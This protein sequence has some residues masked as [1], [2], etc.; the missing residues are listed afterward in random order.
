MRRLYLRI[1]LAVLVSLAVFALC[2]AVVWRQLGDTGPAGHAFEVA[3]TLA[4]NVLP[5]AGAPKAEQQAALEKFA[6]N[7]RADVT[8][9]ATD[10]SLL[11]AV[12]EPVPAPGTGRDRSGWLHR[13]GGPSSGAI[14]LP[15]GRWLVAGVPR[16]RGHPGF[17]L[18]FVLALIALG[19]GVGAY[20]VVRRLT[21]RLERLQ[22]GVESLGA[23]DLSARVKVEGHDEVAR[24]AE[25]FNRGRGGAA[26]LRPWARHSGRG[27]RG[28]VSTVPPVRGRPG[29]RGG[30]IG[31]I[32]GPPDRAPTR[33]RCAVRRTRAVREL[34]RH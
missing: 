17:P 20:P 30:R 13:W 1:Y 24:L 21:V 2:S 28:R 19:V 8:L 15:D 6:A 7:L 12:G 31:A 23:G 5:P 16:G 26:R 11:A 33:R 34:L 27:A 25:S 29:Q 10:R 32:A 22:A 14:H 4:Q 3:G 9:F 18:F